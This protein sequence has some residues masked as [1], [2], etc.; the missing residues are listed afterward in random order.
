MAASTFFSAVRR[1]R[2]AREL[3]VL[4]GMLSQ[5][6]V[7]SQASESTGFC[8][9]EEVT[10]SELD[11][12]AIPGATELGAAYET[13]SRPMV[14]GISAE[15]SLAQQ[16][17]TFCIHPWMHLR[18]QPEGQAQVCCRYQNSISKD[19]S[20]LSLHTN[21]LDEIW[22]SDEMR[23]IRRDMVQGKELAG[24]VECYREE[25]HGGFS[26]RMRD[27]AAW[28]SGWLNEDKVTIDTL[29]SR[30]ILDNFWLSTLPVNLEVDTGSL[31]NLK[32]R[33]CHDGVSSRI[34]K[35]VV[36]SSWTADQWTG[37]PYHD[38]DAI[39]RLLSVRR[40]S[41]PKDFV[42]NAI[43][44]H[45]LETKRLYFI[46][47]EPFLVKEVGDLLQKL[48]DAGVS[49]TMTLAVVSNGT[50]TSSWFELTKHF[51]RLELAVSIDGF[52]KYYD[53][54]RY[55]NKWASLVR[56]IA[57]FRQLPNVHLSAAVT[58]Q[59]Y[60]ALNIDQLF[61]YLD[62]IDL[63]FYAY[64]IHV[65]TYLSIGAMPPRA[66]GLAAERLRAYA[67]TDCRPQH[68]EMVVGLADQLEPTSNT[69]DERLLRDF[70]LFT[71]DLDVSR[72][73]S[74]GEVHGEFLEVLSAIGITWT[75]ETLHA[76]RPVPT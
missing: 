26:M 63:G 23:T 48:I 38:R 62:V 33:M 40:W 65:P 20:P 74:F 64:P 8:P 21:S 11:L 12:S 22:N 59:I 54:I 30:A 18:L 27:N 56:N 19:G 25:K 41:L 2:L 43:L 52:G 31:C 24:C 47:G 69:F 35:D 5:R 32:C 68:R 6:L 13:S 10:R 3:S 4:C 73:Q 42:Q 57:V 15:S 1:S 67:E 14:Q 53:Y 28:Q 9:R 44:R 16:S 39:S 37:K 66:R 55:P 50:F 46:G 71:N 76:R 72:K 61:R 34:A 17:D 29:K 75:M 45:P 7:P 51:R 60:N 36:H 70:M 49:Q 58:L